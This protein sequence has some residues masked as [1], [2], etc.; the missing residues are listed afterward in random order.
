M[1][2]M[3]RRIGFGEKLSRMKTG[4]QFGN[5]P[6][7]TNPG[8]RFLVIFKRDTYNPLSSSLTSRSH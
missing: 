4:Q 5:N 1:P 2:V 8:E 6:E 3:E 7:S